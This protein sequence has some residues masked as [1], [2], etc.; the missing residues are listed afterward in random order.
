MSRRRGGEEEV[1]EG[2]QEVSGGCAVLRE[3]TW[4]AG[5]EQEQECGESEACS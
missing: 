3:V 5:E 4:N 2:Q 1:G